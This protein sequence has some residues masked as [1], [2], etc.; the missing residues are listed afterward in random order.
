M[1]AEILRLPRAYRDRGTGMEQRFPKN[2]HLFKFCQ[3]AQALGGLGVGV[4]EYFRVRLGPGPAGRE[5]PAAAN[6]VRDTGRA[7]G[8]QQLGELR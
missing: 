6:G 2:A 5:D 3:C 4:G 1:Q 7:R 8:V